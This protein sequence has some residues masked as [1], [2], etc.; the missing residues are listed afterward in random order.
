MRMKAV[1][2][3]GQ[4]MLEYVLV[5]GALLLVVTA[6]IVFSQVA[7]SHSS[8]TQALVSADCP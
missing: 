4:A 8:R 5:I 1:M 7:M 6:L 2:R 3:M